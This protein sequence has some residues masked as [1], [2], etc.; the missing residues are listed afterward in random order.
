MTATDAAYTALT[1]ALEG[2]EQLCLDDA[3]FTQDTTNDDAELAELCAVCPVQ[4]ACHAYALTARPDAGF[5][6]GQR[7]RR[8]YKTREPKGTQ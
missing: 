7:W 4:A 3:R 1:Y 8:T 2:G 6:A 5:W